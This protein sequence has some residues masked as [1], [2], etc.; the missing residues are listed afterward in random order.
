MNFVLS[1]LSFA[2][3]QNVTTKRNG[4]FIR[5]NPL[6]AAVKQGVF[7]EKRACMFEWRRS[8]HEFKPAA[9]TPCLTGSFGKAKT[10]AVGSSFFAYFL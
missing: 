4:Y 5:P 9:Q 6:E 1:I 3:I 10:C 7:A 2:Q 8:R